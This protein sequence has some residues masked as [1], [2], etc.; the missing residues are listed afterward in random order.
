MQKLRDILVIF[1]LFLD[2]ILLLLLYVTSLTLNHSVFEL[3]IVNILIFVPKV[4]ETKCLIFVPKV[5][6]TKWM[7][8]KG[9]KESIFIN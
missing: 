2:M 9:I 8:R 1:F 5:N 7:K 4:N 6:K 3:I